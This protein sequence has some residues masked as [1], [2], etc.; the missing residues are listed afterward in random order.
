VLELGDDGLILGGV[1]GLSELG[2]NGLD[3]SWLGWQ[4]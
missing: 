1:L 2:D 4:R 3:L